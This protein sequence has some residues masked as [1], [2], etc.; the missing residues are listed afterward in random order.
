MALSGVMTVLITFSD[1]EK[2][3]FISKWLEGSVW[4]TD[5]TFVTAILPW[6]VLLLPYALWKSRRLDLLG[7]DEA[8][9]IGL[10]G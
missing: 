2:I 5:W 7:L 3:D 10:G 8:T 4:G 1:R 6:I 9:T